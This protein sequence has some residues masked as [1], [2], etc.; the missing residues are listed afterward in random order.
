MN[1][2]AWSEMSY[3]ERGDE[4]KALPWLTTSTPPPQ[5]LIVSPTLLPP[6]RSKRE[7]GRIF[8]FEEESRKKREQ[9]ER[10]KRKREKD[11]EIMRKAREEPN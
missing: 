8:E 3:G 2:P 11:N 10:E 5:K 6:C 9:K 1:K 7:E 4:R